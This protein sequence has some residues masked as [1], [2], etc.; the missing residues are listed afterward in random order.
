[1]SHRSEVGLQ[2]RLSIRPSHIGNTY[3]DTGIVD[4]LEEHRMI[5]IDRRRRSVAFGFH[6]TATTRLC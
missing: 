3:R 2:G 1:M 4:A 5:D 6:V